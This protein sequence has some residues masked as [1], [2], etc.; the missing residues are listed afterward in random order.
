MSNSSLPVSPESPGLQACLAKMTAAGVSEVAI[1][2]FEFNYRALAS[3]AEM[4]IPESS[5]RLVDSLPTLASLRE[6]SAADASDLLKQAVVI[7]LNGGLGTGMGL[8]KAKSLLVVREGMTFLDLTAQQILFLRERFG[9]PLRFLLMNSFSTSADTLAFLARYPGLGSAEDL[10]FVQSQAPKIDAETMAPVVWP[11]DPSQEWCPPGHGDLYPSFLSSGRLD[12]LLDAGVRYAFVSNSDNLGA[13]LDLDLLRYFARSGKP[14]LMEVTRRT[15]ADRKGGHLAIDASSG[16]LLLRESSQ[17]PPADSEAFQDI[18]R[19]RYF[20]TNNLWVRL[21]FLKN[22]LD[23]QGGF[24]PLAVIRNRKTVDP[25][26]SSSPAVFQLET[27]MGAAISCFEGAGAVEVART[28]FAPVKTTD[29]LFALR[30]DAYVV[31]SDFRLELH[32]ERNG[33]PPV[34]R[35]DGAHYKMVDQLESALVGGA[36]SLLACERL[37]ISGP[38][39]FAEGVR[40]AGVVNV[41]NTSG[42]VRDL[43]AGDYSGD[44]EW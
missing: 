34:V 16:G 41:V 9:M 4:M 10:E 19:H 22:A 38:V 13:T 3:G 26:D 30:S 44:V 21:D 2:A 29:D 1:R 14:F 7:K 12:M 32:P 39:R 25:R 6:D 43:P 5:I 33:T 17:C 37:A 27:A 8:Q 11:E 36:P 15:E 35:L 31:T 42:K 24:L 28:R 23:A 20:N 18:G 40:F